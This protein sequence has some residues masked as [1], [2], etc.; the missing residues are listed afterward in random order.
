M[1]GPP[2]QDLKIINKRACDMGRPERQ[3]R[4]RKAATRNILGWYTVNLL[5]G[6]SVLHLRSSAKKHRNKGQFVN[7]PF[8]TWQT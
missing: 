7:C 2:G 6:H 5:V 1:K 8:T 4:E 3:E